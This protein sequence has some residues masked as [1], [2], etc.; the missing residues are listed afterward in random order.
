MYL[1]I[2]ARLIGRPTPTLHLHSI[3][4]L[5]IPKTVETVTGSDEFTFHN[6]SINSNEC[7]ADGKF[8][9]IYIP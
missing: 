6:V 4:Y 8:I 5:L 3:M 2:H 7:F 1:L 9:N